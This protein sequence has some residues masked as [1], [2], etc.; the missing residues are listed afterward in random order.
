MERGHL[1]TVAPTG[2]FTTTQSSRERERLFKK[3]SMQKN[4]KGNN[5]MIALVMF[6]EIHCIEHMTSL[7]PIGFYAKWSTCPRVRQNIDRG[8]SISAPRRRWF[9]NNSKLAFCTLVHGKCVKM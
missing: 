9:F 3:L 7:A 6:S 8:E 2:I 1:F 5:S 4:M